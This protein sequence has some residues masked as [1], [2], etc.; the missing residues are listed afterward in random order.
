MSKKPILLIVDDEKAILKTFKDALEEEHFIVYT[1]DNSVKLL[2]MLGELVPDLLLL[3]IFMPNVNGLDLLVSLK[4]EY[5]DQ[6]VMIIS[7]FGTIPMAVEALRLGAVDFIEKPLNLDDLLI[8]LSFLQKE[9]VN[10]YD[11]DIA[12]QVLQQPVEIIG[13]SYLFRELMRSVEQIALLPLPTLLY[14]EHGVG[15]TLLALYIHRKKY[16]TED[17]FFVFDCQIQT[18][19]S[20]LKDKLLSMPSGTVYLKNIHTASHYV[21]QELVGILYDSPLEGISFIAS[22]SESLYSLVRQQKFSAVLFNYFNS[23]PIAIPSLNKR[24]YDIPLLVHYFLDQENKQQHKSVVLSASSIRKLRNKT[25]VGNVRQLKD[26]IQAL[27]TLVPAN[28]DSVTPALLEYYFPL[29]DAACVEEQSFNQF[30]SLKKATSAFEKEFLL[31]ALKK[32]KYDMQQASD[33][34]NVTIAELHDKMFELCIISKEKML[35]E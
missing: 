2:D 31:Y 17:L 6:K 34:L 23:I 15:K 16:H 33:Y 11:L 7:G 9:Y 12:T 20:S 30:S 24:R 25:W 32:N 29:F 10:D 19:S 27:V 4:K 5:P 3:D 26:F 21:Q 35:F 8:K 13:Q 22:S 18:D 1:L 28:I 14:G